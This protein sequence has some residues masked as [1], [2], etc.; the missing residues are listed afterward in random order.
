MFLTNLQIHKKATYS[1]SLVQWFYPPY[2][3][4]PFPALYQLMTLVF[5][6]AAFGILF[7]I[8]N[9][10][11]YH[12]KLSALPVAFLVNNQEQDTILVH[13]TTLQDHFSLSES[14]EV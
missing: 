5:V 13:L 2:L 4:T 10:T 8:Y 14:E 9:D 1:H 12:D 7:D 3:A 11:V 6:K